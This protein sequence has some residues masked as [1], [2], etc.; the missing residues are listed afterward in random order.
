MINNALIANTNQIQQYPN[1]FPNILPNI[2]NMENK[3]ISLEDKVNQIS[4]HMT[5]IENTLKVIL[6]NSNKK[7]EYKNNSTSTNKDSELK[8]LLKTLIDMQFYTLEK[9]KKLESHNSINKQEEDEFEKMIEKNRPTEKKYS[10]LQKE[11]KS[12]EEFL[13]DP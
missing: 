9:L 6:E 7:Q 3:L 5:G 2:Q 4:N 12:E 8:P 10:F 1:K 13:R 11:K